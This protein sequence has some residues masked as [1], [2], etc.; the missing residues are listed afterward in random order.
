MDPASKEDPERA[1][2][3]GQAKVPRPPT[4]EEVEEVSKAQSLV[5]DDWTGEGGAPPDTPPASGSPDRD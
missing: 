5:T 2:E 3:R 1:P 4:P